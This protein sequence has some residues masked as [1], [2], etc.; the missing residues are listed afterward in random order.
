MTWHITYATHIKC[1]W[2][3]NRHYQSI[4][5]NKLYGTHF[6]CMCV[7]LVVWRSK[8]LCASAAQHKTNQHTRIHCKHNRLIWSKHTQYIIQSLSW[9]VKCA[10][11]T[12]ILRVYITSSWKWVRLH[13]IYY[14][15]L[16]YTLVCCS[17]CS[18]GCDPPS[19]ARDRTRMACNILVNVCTIWRAHTFGTNEICPNVHGV[20][21]VCN[22]RPPTPIWCNGHGTHSSGGTKRN[23]LFRIRKLANNANVIV[24]YCLGRSRCLCIV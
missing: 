9:S 7:R 15:Y 1:R 17:C 21:W 8:C 5:N 16:K 20:K 3:W 6:D 22:A 14:Y 4:K 13:C 23:I 18:A 12:P 24:I 19:R 2:N 11:H 10:M